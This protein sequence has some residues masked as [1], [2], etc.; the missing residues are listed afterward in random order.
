VTSLIESIASGAIPLRDAAG[1]RNRDIA[2]LAHLARTAYEGGR[3]AHAA[4]IF[5]GLEALESDQPLHA[6]HRA[7]AESRA[8]ADDDALESVT[9]FI[10]SSDGVDQDDFVRALVLRAMLLANTDETAAERDLDMARQCQ[11]AVCA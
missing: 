3:F 11:R 6:L 7:Y 2:A 1:L 10:E 9:R 5:A 4:V 8:G